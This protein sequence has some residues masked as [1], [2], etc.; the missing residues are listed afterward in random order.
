M[1]RPVRLTMM[2][3]HN[4]LCPLA[5]RRAEVLEMIDKAGREGTD[6]LVLPECADHHRTHEAVEAHAKG[7]AAVREVLSL[8]LDSP[9]MREVIAYARK[10]KMVIVD[11]CVYRD[12]PKTLNAALV[13]G[14][15]GNLLGT[16][17]KSHL[18]PGEEKVYDWGEKLDVIKTPFGNLGIMICW[19]FHFPEIARVYQLKG[20]DI[21]IWSTMP[22]S[23]FEREFY[24]HAIQS[25]CLYTGLPLGVSTY[26][27]D[28][29]LQKRS[30]MTSVILDNCG[31][32]VAGGI[33]AKNALVKATID[34]DHRACI[35]KDWELGENLD[36]ARF[37]QSLRRPELYGAIAKKE[38][39][40][41]A[42]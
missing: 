21:L 36:Y 37:I 32:T 40:V 26:A 33:Q 17:A 19:D 22:Q 14:P 9:W 5:E 3:I 1:A 42:K 7:R 34:L 35:P 2:T 10:Y 6:I 13:F 29:Q 20:A 23:T 12:G 11:L 4:K 8:S 31:M 28:E 16:Y 25:T 27:V 15:D 30:C 38:E 24:N 39:A 41:G 18:A